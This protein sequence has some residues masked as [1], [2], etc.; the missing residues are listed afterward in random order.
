MAREKALKNIASGVYGA[1][2]SRNNDL[3]GYWGLGKLRSLAQQHGVRRVQLDLLAATIVPA[4]CH[5]APLLKRYS[6]YLQNRL[7][8]SDVPPARVAR[9]VV[10]LDF[11]PDVPAQAPWPCCGGDLFKLTV[12]IVSD[13]DRVCQIDGYGHCHPHSPSREFRSTR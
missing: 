9:A 13:A 10:E 3:D 5:F 1:F 11:E 7:A 6:T 12:S 2:V 4:D 8:G